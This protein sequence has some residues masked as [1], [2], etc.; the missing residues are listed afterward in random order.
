M[1]YKYTGQILAKPHTPTRRNRR[2][3]IGKT[4]ITLLLLSQATAPTVFS[5]SV[6]G[7][8]YPVHWRSHPFSEARARKCF[9]FPGVKPFEVV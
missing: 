4:S 3:P 7:V 8:V 1:P 6:Q 5:S 2:L 9:I